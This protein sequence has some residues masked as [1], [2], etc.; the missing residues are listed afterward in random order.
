MNVV[1]VE[2]K[3]RALEVKEKELRRKESRG[4]SGRGVI[5]RYTEAPAL[6]PRSNAGIIADILH[7]MHVERR[8]RVGNVTAARG[9]T[10]PQSANAARPASAIPPRAPPHRAVPTVV[11]ALGVD[12]AQNFLKAFTY[13]PRKAVQ[14]F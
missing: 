9:P 13:Q 8:A 6:S 3:F 11:D 10:R 5:S 7:D 1:Q 12:A 14:T 2:R 4:M